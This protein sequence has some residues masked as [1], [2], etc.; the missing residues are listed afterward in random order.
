MC[1]LQTIEGKLPGR[2]HYRVLYLSNIVRD[3]DADSVTTSVVPSAY[4]NE[5]MQVLSEQPGKI[6]TASSVMITS[7]DQIEWLYGRQDGYLSYHSFFDNATL[8]T[9]RLSC[10][11]PRLG[12]NAIGARTVVARPYRLV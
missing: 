7:I 8:N 9:R 11:S 4:V 1:R 12:L 10:D 2:G 6:H 5:E 3:I